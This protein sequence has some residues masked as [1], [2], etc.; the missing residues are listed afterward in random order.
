LIDL[1]QIF[2][3]Q[4]VERPEVFRLGFRQFHI[5]GHDQLLIRS[6]F[7]AQNFKIVGGLVLRQTQDRATEQHA[8]E[9]NSR[10]AFY[11][12]DFHR[13][14]PSMRTSKSEIIKRVIQKS[15]S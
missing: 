5:G 13:V 12:T 7:I 11:K 15:I 14:S 4:L 10:S 1:L 9:Q 6:D 8:H 2:L 3:V